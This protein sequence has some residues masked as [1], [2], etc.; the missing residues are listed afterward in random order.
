MSKQFQARYPSDPE[1]S[2][3]EPNDAK[4]PFRLAFEV[5]EAF[6]EEDFT[7]NPDGNWGTKANHEVIVREVIKDGFGPEE[8]YTVEIDFWPSFAAYKKDS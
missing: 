5:A 4:F 2:D 8:A 3:V 7:Y 1:W 6:V